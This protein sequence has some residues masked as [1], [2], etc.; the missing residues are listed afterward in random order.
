MGLFRNLLHIRTAKKEISRNP[1]YQIIVAHV[2]KDIHESPHE[3]IQKLPEESREKIIQEICNAT[4]TIWQT[5]DR[6]L[7]NREMLL[8]TML[9]QAQYEILMIES[10][11]W[12]CSFHGISGQ[13]KEY[14]PEFAQAQIESG[15]F[16]WTQKDKPTKDEAYIL[17]WGKFWRANL[18]YNIL[19]ETRIYLKDHNTNIERDW[20]FPLQYA[21]TAFVEYKFRKEYGLKQLLEDICAIQY[22][23]F[24]D[25]V[26]QGYKDPLAKWETNYNKVFPIPPK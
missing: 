2:Q 3:L 12:L 25:V 4:E 8:E 6:I 22:S 14:L 9:N 16:V 15:D 5:P 10:D 26:L 18:Y 19:N 13:L 23:S 17:V 21:L 24:L 1:L 11:H 20:L 7:G